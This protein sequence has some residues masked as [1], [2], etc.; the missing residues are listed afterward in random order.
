[1]SSPQDL[2]ATIQ[3]ILERLQAQCDE[4]A[5]LQHGP[6]DP[7]DDYNR[8]ESRFASRDFVDSRIMRCDDQIAEHKLTLIEILEVQAKMFDVLTLNTNYLLSHIPPYPSDELEVDVVQPRPEL[9]EDD[10]SPILINTL[11]IVPLQ[12]GFAADLLRGIPL[13]KTLKVYPSDIDEEPPHSD[14]STESQANMWC[15]R[16]LDDLRERAGIQPEHLQYDELYDDDIMDFC[17]DG[18][19]RSDDDFESEAILSDYSE[20]V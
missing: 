17:G 14:Y 19:P 3:D 4:A 1:M 15:S 12:D 18:Q 6:Y 10:Y 7:Y 2:R 5:S 9:K 8:G 13:N 20:E 16:E 11:P